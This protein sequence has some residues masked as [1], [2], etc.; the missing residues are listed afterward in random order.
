MTTL[1]APT[2][3][4]RPVGMAYSAPL[5]GLRGLA[6]AAIVVYHAGVG[7][8]PGAFLS[9]STFFTLSGFLITALLLGEHER[10]GG[11][12]LRGFWSR[13][14]RR[15]M[16][17]ALAAI[18]AIT[19]A[20][21]LL[22]DS[23]QLARLRADALAALAYVANW[24]FIAV[25]DTYGAG[26]DSPSPFTHFWT[27][28]IEEQFYIVL[29]LVVVAIL[30]LGRGSRR[31]V[32]AGLAV[33]A[34]GSLAWSVLLESRGASTDRLY[35]GTDV[36]S[37]ELLAGALLAVWWMRRRDPWPPGLRRWVRVAAPVALAVMVASWLTAELT[38]RRFYQGGL[39]LYSG[40]T[41]VVVLGCLE[42]TGPVAR[43]LG[44]RP[45]VWIGT[46]SYA[47]YLVHYPLLIWM[48]SY[49]SW[50]AW[51]RLAVAVPV[52]LGIAAVSARLL[53][54]PIRRGAWL[55][56]PARAAWSALGAALATLL[57]VLLVGTAV[58]PEER[59]D[60]DAAERWQRAL[61]EEMAE[62]DPD[63]PKVAM[64]GDS[65]ALMTSRGLD[66]FARL[67][68][69]RMSF[70]PGWTALGCGLLTE[71]DRVIRGELVPPDEECRGWEQRWAAASEEHPSDLAVVQLG[72]W[73]VV[74]QQLS[75]GGEILTIGEDPEVDGAI[76]AALL[77]AVDVLR[78]DNGTVVLLAPPDIEV[79]RVDGRSPPSPYDESDP[80]RME[81]FRE[82][83]TDVARDRPDVEVI[84]LQPWFAAR[85]DRRLRPDGVHLTDETTHELSAWLAPRLLELHEQ[86]TG[87]Q[88]TAVAGR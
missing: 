79:G 77:R 57:A 88:G 59:L 71:G 28:A 75:P 24:R 52:I 61:Q 25:G 83:V 40:L 6:L 63:A 19:L 58:A 55:R 68:P 9:V 11:V 73:E 7:A 56:S 31:A 13:R 39:V 67:N 53:E 51:V 4:P 60:L 12:S 82:I 84:D 48:G 17:A 80:E 36:R 29:P 47:A 30:A 46:V 14:L 78:A 1:D 32:A 33:V 2:R 87:S 15:L 74:D 3:T 69:E 70:N 42:G 18:V 16:P 26:F 22:A 86:A 8:A 10:D 21:A 38:D 41:L 43:V 49:L 66:E 44:W 34:A 85:D 76:R 50:P 62:R 54:R 27:L 64:F 5:D 37:A 20:A 45:L 35:F 65:S 23:T 72:P 81:R